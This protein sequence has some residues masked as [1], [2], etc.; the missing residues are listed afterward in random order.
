MRRWLQNSAFPEDNLA[1]RAMVFG[2]ALVADA[3][4]GLTA[5]ATL[6]ALVCVAFVGAGHVVSY[7]GRHRPRTGAG[8]LVL[9]LLLGSAL[10][11]LVADLTTGVFGGELPQAKFGLLAQAI[12]S[13][14]LKSRRNLFSHV[15]ISA[16]IL[17][18]GALFAWDPTFVVYVLAWSS[19]F[20]AFLLAT[21]HVS[22]TPGRPGWR[23]WLTARL[24]R[25]APAIAA[26]LV[27]GGVAFLALPRFAGRP[28]AVPLLVSIPLDQQAGEILPAVLPL[29]GTTPSGS[30]EAG[31]NL[32]VRGRLGD[33]VMF[34]VRAP[35]A[36]YWRA[37]VLEEYRG[38]AWGRVLHQAIPLPPISTNI[39]VGD[40]DTST[41]GS[42]PQSFYIER[43]LPAEVLASY[44][45]RELYFPAR[46]LVL[47]STGTV[48]APY[49]L[50][51]GVNY[52]A[53]SQ[54][55]DTS[56]A[57]L[58]AAGPLPDNAVD[59]AD[60]AVPA[61]VPARV[62]RLADELAAG[63]PTEY[64]RVERIGLYLRSH[65][66]YSLD[67]PRLPSG[68]DAVDQFLFV[69][70]VGFCE[71]FASAFT[72][73][74][75]DAGIPARLAVGF[76][77][78]DHDA[79]T[80]T[81]TVHARDAHAWVEV[82][83]PGVGWIPFDASPGFVGEPTAGTP[84]RWL[85]GDFSPQ[86]AFI[87][88]GNARPGTIGLAGAALLATALVVVL[89]R[90]RRLAEMPAE[91]RLYL[92]AQPVLRFGRL[93][94]RE[95]AE[96]PAEHLS[97]VQR[98]SPLAAARLA[99]LVAALERVLYRPVG[100]REPRASLLPLIVTALSRRLGARG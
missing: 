94:S 7:R 28:L 14:D 73:L 37:Y 45:L 85:L 92:A 44:P 60:L 41:G 38:Q 88:L 36:S 23:P 77:T 91:V 96:T 82:L 67:T 11:Y 55:R 33:E 62:Q 8:Q 63:A 50:R 98:T 39:P 64:D 79:I 43:P 74:L 90:R 4:L 12:T 59:D 46:Q 93:P 27:I 97:R 35:A 61:S 58:R 25:A 49:G 56:P 66:R 78:G 89:I 71:Q 17:Y 13:F 47:T 86:L 10:V 9:A 22:T 69:D 40:E 26:W 32:R 24:R 48:H 57:A 5:G 100:A 2:T 20:F 30:G 72:I 34:R 21:A 95:R 3:A 19:C 53:V 70:R 68:A 42:L 99:P 16:T 65:Y 29:V 87:G 6:V 1:G 54:V 84:S 31:I 18:V 76:A 15:W 83:F 51:K 81:F 75:R 52:S 80:G